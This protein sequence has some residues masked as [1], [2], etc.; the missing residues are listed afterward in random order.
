MALNEKKSKRG[1]NIR[2]ACHTRIWLML[3]ALPSDISHF[4]KMLHDVHEVMDI[5][6][7]HIYCTYG[8]NTYSCGQDIS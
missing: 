3:N 7:H 4:A 8:Y 1:V 2:C 6:G 5:R